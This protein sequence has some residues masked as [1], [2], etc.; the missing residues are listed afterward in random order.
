MNSKSMNEKLPQV[1][2]IADIISRMGKEK[3]EIWNLYKRDVN[4]PSPV[5]HVNN[6][7]TPIFSLVEIEKYFNLNNNS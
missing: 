3:H 1:V 4:F 7:R 2:S 5:Q 6:G